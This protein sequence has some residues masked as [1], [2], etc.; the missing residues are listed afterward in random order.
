MASLQRGIANIALNDRSP[1]RPA[2]GSSGTVTELLT[3]HA[4]LDFSQAKNF[5]LHQYSIAVLSETRGNRWQNEVVS[6]PEIKGRKKTQLICC[7]LD[8]KPLIKR[9]AEIATDFGSFL[10]TY[11]KLPDEDMPMRCSVQYHLEG[12]EHNSERD[13]VYTV[14]VKYTKALP[15]QPLLDYLS[16]DGP[17][18]AENESRKQSILQTLNIWLG[19][20]SEAH[21]KQVVI[22]GTA[23]SLTPD[24]DSTLQLPGGFTAMRG[25]YSSVRSG[26]DGLMVNLQPKHGV[27]FAPQC[28]LAHFML[29]HRDF[30]KLH[31]R[32]RR[33]RVRATH[34]PP[35]TNAAGEALHPI[36]T[37]LGL[38]RPGDG[39]EASKDGTQLRK[40]PRVDRLH[41]GPK[42]VH[43]WKED[44]SGTGGSWVSVYNYFRER[45]RGVPLNADLPVVNVGTRSH[46]AYLPAEVCIIEP[47][48]SV[49]LDPSQVE[50]MTRFAVRQPDLNAASVKQGLKMIGLDAETNVFSV[51]PQSV[52]RSCGRH[53]VYHMW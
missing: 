31:F 27:F 11:T 6:S 48:Q 25:I 43:F 52:N 29:Q 4:R 16:S 13:S 1:R 50:A 7:L 32:L 22:R 18:N 12:Q 47:G 35:K 5:H 42:D 3:N 45:Y 33:L 17:I 10:V 28:P 14:E 36:K 38:A 20:Y 19:H 2:A 46:P 8:T 51:S 9:K 21:S 53:I 39:K 49:P 44:E 15:L 26:H 41:G 24:R 37:I 34:L 23:F 30:S 40:P